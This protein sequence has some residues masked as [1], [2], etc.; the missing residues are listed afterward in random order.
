VCR[1]APRLGLGEEELLEELE[2]VRGGSHAV[3]DGSLV[4]EDLVVVSTGV[5]LRKASVSEGR[6][7]TSG[8]VICRARGRRMGREIR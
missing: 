6:G 2:R 8:P 4:G 3:A 1:V 5:S 7:D